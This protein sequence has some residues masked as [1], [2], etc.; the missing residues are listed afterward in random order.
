MEYFLRIICLIFLCFFNVTNV[1]AKNKV[2][3]FVSILPQQYFVQQVGAE[4]VDVHVMVSPGQNPSTYEPTAQQMAALAKADIYFSI[5][6]PF[7]SVWL[8]K[9]KKNNRELIIVECCDSISDLKGHTHHDGEHHD[10]H[11]WT[12]PKKVIQIVK[13]I[14]KSLIE[15]D[16]ENSQ[17][18]ENSSNY[19]INKLKDLDENIRSKISNLEKRNLIVSHPSWSYFANEYGLT[20]ISIEHNGKEI[21]AR[22]MVKLI[23]SAKENNI[24]A[25]F[26]QSQFSDKAAI[27]IAK[28]L[29]ANIYE[30]DPLAL[31]Y[32]ENMKYVTEIIVEGLSRE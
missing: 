27:V 13:L 25:I 9:I 5:G 24:K 28:E 32:L 12:S 16:K 14:E 1:Y 15:F 2:E 11:V 8:D 17:Y 26:V 19:F 4:Y 20:Q 23:Q 18:Y 29:N 10:P 21:R 3:V 6:V 31:N 22:S 7:E 30:L